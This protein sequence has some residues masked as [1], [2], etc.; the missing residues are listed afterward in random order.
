MIGEP[1]YWAL[2]AFGAVINFI[3]SI[4]E[5]RKAA[6][7]K[8]G[9]RQYL[10]DKPYAASLGVMGGIAA[11]FWMADAATAPKWGLVAGLAGTTFLERL[12]KRRP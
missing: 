12:A 6:E 4:R 2:V 8:V 3:L 1:L 5:A 7:V 10:R 11:G 9:I